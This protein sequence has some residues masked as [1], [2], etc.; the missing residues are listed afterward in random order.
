MNKIQPVFGIGTNREGI[1][2]TNDSWDGNAMEAG[3]DIFTKMRDMDIRE[4]DRETLADILE[5]EI[6]RGLSEA[7][8]KREFLRQM[9]N[10]YL[11]KQGE[12]IVKLSF[13]DTDAT[14]TDRLKEYIEHVAAA[15]VLSGGGGG[16]CGEGDASERV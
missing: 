16:V 13:A 15:G 2:C 5:I 11:Y 6:D 7:D 8:R 10:P 14:L 4:A 3:Q 9:K 1:Y 12:Y